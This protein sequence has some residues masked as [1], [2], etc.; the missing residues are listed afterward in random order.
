MATV[1]PSGA[2]D[3][4]VGTGEVKDGFILFNLNVDLLK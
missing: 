3:V 2:G 1:R 4:A